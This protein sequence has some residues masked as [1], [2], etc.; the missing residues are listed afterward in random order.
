MNKGYGAQGT[1]LRAQDPEADIF[2]LFALKEAGVTRNVII[3]RKVKIIFL[4]RLFEREEFNRMK[5]IIFSE[6]AKR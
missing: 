3:D 4:T 5:D 2:G 6:L 1:E